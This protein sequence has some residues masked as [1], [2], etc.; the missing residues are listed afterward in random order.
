M[1]EEARVWHKRLKDFQELLS[2]NY[3]R[4]KLVSVTLLIKGET[5][6]CA[7]EEVELLI[8]ASPRYKVIA[9]AKK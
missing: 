2:L 3:D 5:V 6:V 8:Y 9:E 1:E 4:G 7:P